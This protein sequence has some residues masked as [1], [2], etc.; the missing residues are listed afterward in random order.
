[1]LLLVS[2]NTW[3]QIACVQ[4]ES[5]KEEKKIEPRGTYVHDRRVTMDKV[6]GVTP[7][8]TKKYLLPYGDIMHEHDITESNRHDSCIGKLRRICRVKQTKPTTHGRHRLHMVVMMIK[9]LNIY[10][11]LPY[12]FSMEEQLFK[13]VSLTSR[14]GFPVFPL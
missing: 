14:S 3:T 12:H 5:R 9:Y 11:I 4:G 1:M 10:M 2:V 8:H 6:S 13:T 7:Y